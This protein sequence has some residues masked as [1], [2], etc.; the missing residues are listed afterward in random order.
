MRN[1]PDR[2]KR[3]GGIQRCGRTVSPEIT[4]VPIISN[5]DR[6]YALHRPILSCLKVIR[7]SVICS[8]YFKNCPAAWTNPKLKLTQKRVGS[9]KSLT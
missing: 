5:F 4:S 8:S 6:P 3:R 9:F 2:G 7:Y 1:H